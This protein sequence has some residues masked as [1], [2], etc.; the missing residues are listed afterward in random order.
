MLPF[1]FEQLDKKSSSSIF[2]LYFILQKNELLTPEHGLTQLGLISEERDVCREKSIYGYIQLLLIT[3]CIDDSFLCAGNR[4]GQLLLHHAN[5]FRMQV[6]KETLSN[7]VILRTDRRTL[8]GGLTLHSSVHTKVN[9]NDWH[10][11]KR[12]QFFLKHNRN[13]EQH[14]HGCSSG[15]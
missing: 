4:C 11:E 9:S 2:L 3:F 12:F 6:I 7:Q 13:T 1:I 5:V 15:S 10:N 14:L 8:K